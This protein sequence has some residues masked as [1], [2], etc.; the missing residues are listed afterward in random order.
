MLPTRLLVFQG[1]FGQFRQRGWGVWTET[2]KETRE[3]PGLSDRPTT[4][5]GVVGGVWGEGTGAP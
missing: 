5:Q 3:P 4:V 2:E 1:V